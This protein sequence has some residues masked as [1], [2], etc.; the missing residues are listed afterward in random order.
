MLLFAFAFN[1]TKMRE[2]PEA[3]DL[4]RNIRPVYTGKVCIV[5]I[6]VRSIHWELTVA[7]HVAH[8]IQSHRHPYIIHPF[9]H[10]CLAIFCTKNV[11]PF[12]ISRVRIYRII[13][14]LLWCF[15]CLPMS[16]LVMRYVL[17]FSIS[18]SKKID[19]MWIPCVP[20]E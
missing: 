8:Y 15:C 12:I 19:L 18:L 6:L 3:Y 10:Q 20:V 7:L 5:V 9:Y 4:H 17:L 14:V 11:I 13:P 2:N 1:S 16:F